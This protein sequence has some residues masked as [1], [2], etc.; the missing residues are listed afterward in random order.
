MTAANPERILFDEKSICT[1]NFMENLLYQHKNAIWMLEAKDD[2]IVELTPDMRQEI[3]DIHACWFVNWVLDGIKRE[4]THA[5]DPP[6]DRS[7]TVLSKVM[8]ECTL[9]NLYKTL[10][11]WMGEE[12]TGNRTATYESGY[13]LSADNF[14][15]EIHDSIER[16]IWEGFRAQFTD[17][18]DLDIEEILGDSDAYCLGIYGFASALVV[19]LGRMQTEEVWKKFKDQEIH[20]R[21]LAK[22]AAS[23]KWEFFEALR[24]RSKELKASRLPQITD[25]KIERPQWNEENLGV[26]LEQ[27]LSEADI[28]Y[29]IAVAEVGLPGKFSNSVAADIR[30]IA[31]S[32]LERRIEEAEVVYFLGLLKDSGREMNKE[33]RGLFLK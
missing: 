19:I 30:N 29:V 8:D 33:S 32:V 5:Y 21:K 20:S 10:G 15:R 6:W 26:F 14:G 1:G 23:R 28:E 18:D 22:E 17:D 2:L 11:E 31:K 3:L 24:E 4:I 7:G 25:A 27:V 9:L 12:L 16:G 13:G